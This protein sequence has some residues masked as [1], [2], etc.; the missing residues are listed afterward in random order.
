VVK[1]PQLRRTE[2]ETTPEEGT[3]RTDP[4]ARRPE[5]A[6]RQAPA[7]G[8]EPERGP[9]PAGRP[10]R[11]RRFG[12]RHDRDDRSAV[13]NRKVEQAAERAAEATRSAAAAAAAERSHAR[14]RASVLASIGLVLAVV[15]ALAVA[16]GV[17]TR[18]GVAVGILALLFGLAALTATGRRYRYLA[19][20]IEA[21]TALVLGMVAVVIGGL[22]AAGSLSWLDPDTNYVQR[23]ADWLPGWLS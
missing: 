22:A 4:A 5:P 17:L 16:T 7:R 19:G 13:L 23:L 15:A 20:R 12:R 1:L 2:P 3:G 11:T 6:T 10:A 21:T 18:L 14:A 9:E 8:L